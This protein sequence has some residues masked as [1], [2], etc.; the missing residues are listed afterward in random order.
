M[1]TVEVTSDYIKKKS[2]TDQAVFVVLLWGEIDVLKQNQHVD[3]VTTHHLPCQH[4]E[5]KP[6]CIGE[7]PEH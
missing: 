3:Q 6:G 1:D 2:F 5:L 4:Q 7:W